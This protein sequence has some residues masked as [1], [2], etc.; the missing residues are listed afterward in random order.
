[1]SKC[2]MAEVNHSEYLFAFYLTRVVRKLYNIF[3]IAVQKKINT[4][5]HNK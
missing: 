4:L 3:L 5:K 1:M 2:K